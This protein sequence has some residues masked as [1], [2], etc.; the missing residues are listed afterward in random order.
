MMRFHFHSCSSFLEQQ[1]RTSMW[2][3]NIR[4]QPQH[5]ITPLKGNLKEWE[6]IVVSMSMLVMKIKKMCHYN[7]KIYHTPQTHFSLSRI[8][9]NTSFWSS[10]F[11]A[12]SINSE[13][14]IDYS[15]NHEHNSIE[16][17]CERWLC[18][19]LPCP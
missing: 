15:Y 11:R 12:P 6:Y 5:P 2:S 7:Y 13:P 17:A 10:F 8:S 1:I 16:I 3:A 18:L 19:W 4:L 9:T 14:V